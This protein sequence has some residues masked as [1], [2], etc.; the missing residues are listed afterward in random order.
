[1]S[2]KNLIEA[3]PKDLKRFVLNTSVGVE[4]FGSFPFFILNAFGTLCPC[5]M[6]MN[7]L[8]NMATQRAKHACSAA[9]WYAF[10][11]QESNQV[12]VAPLDMSAGRMNLYLTRPSGDLDIACS[13][14][15]M[16]TGFPPAKLAGVLKF[17][18]EAEKLLQASG[19]PYTIMRPGRLTDGSYLLSRTCCGH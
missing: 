14:G 11:H 15:P 16:L 7:A 18:R 10:W 3:S 9:G 13:F 2:V 1:M 4:R 6:Q 8:L 17:K 12:P 19:L 5:L